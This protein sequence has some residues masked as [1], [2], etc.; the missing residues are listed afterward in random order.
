VINPSFGV[1]WDMDGVLTD[2]GDFHYQAWAPALAEVGLP[3]SRETFRKTFGMTNPEILAQLLGYAPSPDFIRQVSDRKEQEFRR[4]IRGHAKTLPG[5]TTWLERNRQAGASQAVASSAP[6]E[7][8]D[9]LI[10]EL[11]LQSYFVALLSAFNLPGKP[12]PAVFL[13]AARWIG[14]SPDR[15]VVVEDAIVGV[16]AARRAGMKCIAVTTTN[17]P[18][19]L[20]AADIVIDRLDR[21]TPDAFTK[22]LI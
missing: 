22:L 17:P 2:T 14:Q 11:G 4:I 19:A 3:F 16:E 12:D 1:I 20:S 5:A 6:Q 7:N 13:E 21:L 8:I 10:D 15:C 18:E 9:L